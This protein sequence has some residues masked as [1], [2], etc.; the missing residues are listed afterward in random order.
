MSQRTLRV[1][2][3]QFAAHLTSSEVLSDFQIWSS[4]GCQMHLDYVTLRTFSHS[5]SS[6]PRTMSSKLRDRNL[7]LT[8]LP[9]LVMNSQLLFADSLTSTSLDWLG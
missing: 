1:S 8:G 6:S 3:Y 9:V 4:T 5:L 2:P 7:S